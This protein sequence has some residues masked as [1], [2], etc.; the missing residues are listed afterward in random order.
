MKNASKWSGCILS[1]HLLLPKAKF[2]SLGK[3]FLVQKT[4]FGQFRE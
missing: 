2:K 4:P 1:G 3:V